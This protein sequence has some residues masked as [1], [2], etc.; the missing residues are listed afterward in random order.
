MKDLKKKWLQKFTTQFK[1]NKKSSLAT[2]AAAS[3]IF[4]RGFGEKRIELILKELPNIL[5]EDS[6]NEEKINKLKLLMD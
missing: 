6:S 3:N 5:T 1:T 2:I 4:G